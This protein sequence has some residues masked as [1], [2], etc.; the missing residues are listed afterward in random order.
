MMLIRI[1]CQLRERRLSL[2]LGLLLALAMPASAVADNN[3]HLIESLPNG[4][5]IYRCG[6][7]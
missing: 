3:L 2:L 5:A 7:L 6:K 4:F 1:P